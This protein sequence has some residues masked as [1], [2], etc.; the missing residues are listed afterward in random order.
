MQAFDTEEEAISLANDSMYGL[1]AS[2]WST[3][4]DR[5]LRIAWKINAGTVWINNWAIAHSETVEGG[6]KQS[7]LGQLNGLAAMDDFIEYKTVIH[8]VNLKAA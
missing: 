3:N 5:P 4:V 6:Y 1:A 2:V 8:E 7:G